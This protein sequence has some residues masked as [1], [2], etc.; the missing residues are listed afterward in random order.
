MFVEFTSGGPA[1]AE[2]RAVLA[3]VIEGVQHA[4]AQDSGSLVAVLTEAA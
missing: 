3:D 2:Q 1:D 4:D